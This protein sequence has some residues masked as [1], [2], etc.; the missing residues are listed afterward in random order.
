MANS[1]WLWIACSNGL[2]PADLSGDRPGDAVEGHTPDPPNTEEGTLTDVV[3]DTGTAS[4]TD[5]D[6]A[7]PTDSDPG[8][9]SDTGTEPGTETG[10]STDPS[11]EACGDGTCDVSE[12]C[13]ECADDCGACDCPVEA[14]VV[15]YTQAAWNVLADALVADPSPCADYTISLPASATDKTLPR[16][17]GEP[18][19]MRARSSRFHA[20]AEFH[21]TTWAGEGGTW[22]ERGVAFRENMVDAGYD[23]D[24]GD[25]WAI[26]ELPSTVRTDPAVRDDVVEVL[27]GLHDG[28]VGAPDEK[29]VVFIVG[30]GHGTTNFDV[31]KPNVKDL[32]EDADFWV[33]VHKYAKF[34][35]QEV[36]ADPHYV[37]VDG[38][39]VAERSLQINEY[40]EHVHTLSDVGPD[41][42][43]T[44]QSYLGRAYTPLM[45]AVWMSDTGFGDTQVDLDTM[46]HFVSHQVYA[47]RAWSDSHASP[48]GRIGFGWD[49][50]DGVLDIDLTDLGARLASAIHYAYD[51][52]GGQASGACSPSGA[53][54]WCQC[55]VE[56]AAYNDGWETF[57]T[58]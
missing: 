52:G 16:A 10:T 33:G 29:G 36:Y 14:D 20:A 5:A 26:N 3:P 4:E 34:W 39:T 24:K 43:N 6:T 48:D 55:V 32:L 58:W 41:S 50:H 22:Y 15:V 31:Y 9:T 38:E 8:S 37:C 18:E 11:Y 56:D 23:V 21:W 40:V 49:R 44:A 30:M 47:A 42:V 13:W 54:T 28:P 2:P 51:E 1:W 46:K 27:N 19:A 12:G 7:T 45:N 53:F 57:N 35:A 17:E 25:T